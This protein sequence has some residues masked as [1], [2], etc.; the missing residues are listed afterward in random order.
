MEQESDRVERSLVSQL[1]E[2][3]R[4][5]A[6]LLAHGLTEPEAASRLRVSEHTIHE[7]VR[8]IYERLGCHNR[9]QLVTFV[10]RSDIC[11]GQ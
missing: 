10:T 7:H 3:Q 6:C 4:E 1:T 11:A 2:R 8:H 5:V 9:G